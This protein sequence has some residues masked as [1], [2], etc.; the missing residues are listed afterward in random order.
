EKKNEAEKCSK[1]T[2]FDNCRDSE[3]DECGGRQFQVNKQSQISPRL[4]IQV[5]SP[6]KGRKPLH[7]LSSSQRKISSPQPDPKPEKKVA[8]QCLAQK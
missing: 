5:V 2:N 4:P 8:R 3:I 1:G 6:E 7:H